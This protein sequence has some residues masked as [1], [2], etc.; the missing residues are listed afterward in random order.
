[1]YVRRGA[2]ALVFAW[3]MAGS[4][5]HAQWEDYS[6]HWYTN[7]VGTVMPYRLFV[8]N[9]YN[10]TN[11]H[12]LILCL[13]G[14]GG[15]GT[16]NTSQ[17][18][19]SKDM[20]SFFMDQ[21]CLIVAPQ[22][23][24]WWGPDEIQLAHKIVLD[25]RDNYAVDTNRIYV[26]G[27]SQGGHGTWRA[28][29]TYTNTYAAGG[30]VC[31]WGQQWLD[32]TDVPPDYGGRVSA[33]A[34]LLVKTPIWAWHG[35]GDTTVLYNNSLFMIEEIGQAIRNT[36]STVD[37][38]FLKLTTLNGVGHKAYNVAYVDAEF[39]SWLFSQRRDERDP[40]SPPTTL[41]VTLITR[42]QVS[43]EWTA[44]ST[45]AHVDHY[46][47]YRDGI[48][49]ATA[50]PP[51]FVD[52]NVMPGVEYEYAVLAVNHVGLESE[53]CTPLSVTTLAP[54]PNSV[55]YAE[56]FESF[57]PGYEIVDSTGWNGVAGAGVVGSNAPSHAALFP[58][59]A[60]EHKQML[61]ANELT[62][63]LISSSPDQTNVWIDFLVGGVRPSVDE[64]MVDPEDALCALAMTSNLNLMVWNSSLGSNAWTVL[65]DTHLDTGSWAR[66]TVLIDYERSVADAV[67]FR[68]WVD[69]TPVTNPATWYRVCETNSRKLSGI[70][71]QNGAMDDLVVDDYNVLQYRKI[72]ASA[73][74]QG[75][76]IDPLGVSLVDI[77][78]N[79]TFTIQP[80]NWWVLSD[81]LIDDSNSVGTVNDFTFSNVLARH[82]IQ[83]LFAPELATNDIPIWW[84][85]THGLTNASPDTEAL[86]DHD[87]D[88]LLSW[89]EYVSGTSPTNRDSVFRIEHVN[90]PSPTQAVISWQSVSNRTYSILRSTDLSS[91]FET[92]AT[93]ITATPPINVY[94]D[95]VP[96][97]VEL[98]YRC[99]VQ[100]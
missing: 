29:A 36:G 10:P 41:T 82:T 92:H 1:M 46:A 58:L 40:P 97:D 56:S 45:P 61:E 83:A 100:K 17:L 78:S 71:L 19:P 98:F 74:P 13:H 8:H 37:E 5:V 30:P 53:L 73:D 60:A 3:I 16:N 15:R 18:I 11:T 76:S 50:T 26:T 7:E 35:T 34:P 43:I 9:N 66:I 95:S 57:P 2:V 85:Y 6:S 54:I 42:R 28:L 52:D 51:L 49:V 91:G 81:V 65:P 88:G 39:K 12:P 90:H 48:N 20:N 32:A 86:V 67:G 59:P 33:W 77:G 75:G 22:Q 23:N 55:P 31:G 89:E 4:H 64:E 79:I 94:T 99:A 27:L 44:S 24:S 63:C 87:G 68:M 96:V 47:V 84:F 62:S 21:N 70:R 72:E 14:G 69:N 38:R 25:I 93:N 80:T